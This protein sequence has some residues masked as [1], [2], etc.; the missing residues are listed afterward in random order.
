MQKTTQ[1]Y[2]ENVQNIFTSLLLL[3]LW[4]FSEKR[5]MDYF[6]TAITV[7]SITINI[8]NIIITAIS[9]ILDKKV[10]DGGNDEK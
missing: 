2:M 7:V 6:I 4:D 1:S 3:Y 8:V 9:A 10:A 5:K